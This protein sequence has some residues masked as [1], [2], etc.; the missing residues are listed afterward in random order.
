MNNRNAQGGATAM[1]TRNPERAKDIRKLHQLM[2]SLPDEGILAIYFRFWENLL[3]DE[4][5]SILGKTWTETDQILEAAISE[6]RS[7]FVNQNVFQ[8]QAA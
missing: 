7:G 4:I 3:I 6:L 5:A 2:P 8:K 1:P